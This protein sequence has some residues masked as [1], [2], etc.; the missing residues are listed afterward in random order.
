M[1][2]GSVYAKLVLD[3]RRKDEAFV[4]DLVAHGLL[5][6]SPGAPQRR[7][8]VDTRTGKIKRWGIAEFSLVP[9]SAYP[10]AEVSAA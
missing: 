5:S 6:W 8:K 10:R 2:E 4:A 3:M 1:E 9:T 7:A